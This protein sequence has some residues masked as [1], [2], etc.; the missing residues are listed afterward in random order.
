MM[1]G[2]FIMTLVFVTINTDQWQEDFFILTITTIVLLNSK[3]FI[4]VFQESVDLTSAEHSS[5]TFFR[6]SS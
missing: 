1:L 2:L 4:L 6:F 3:I 5:K